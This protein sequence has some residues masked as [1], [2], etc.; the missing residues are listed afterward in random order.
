MSK[1]FV[2]DIVEKTSGNGVQ[3]PGHVIQKQ[4]ATY[5][6]QTDMAT[7][8]WTDTGLTVNITPKSSTSHMLIMIAQ[9]FRIVSSNSDT[10]MSFRILRGSTVIFQPAT[11]YVNYTYNNN[12]YCE[13]RG[14]DYTQHVDAHGS[15][16]QLTYHVK[17]RSYAANPTNRANDA[18]NTSTIIVLEIAQ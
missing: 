1:L 6:T 7:G 9:S 16:S 17:G 2:D 14:V 18:G 12:N 15:S 11:T 4:S 5:S 13:H 10:G 3:I 8:S